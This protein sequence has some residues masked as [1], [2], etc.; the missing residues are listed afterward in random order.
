MQVKVLDTA[1]ALERKIIGWV[2]QSGNGLALNRAAAA[3]TSRHFLHDLAVC[4]FTV[5]GLCLVHVGYRM[6]WNTVIG[7]FLTQI[8]VSFLPGKA[9][10]AED[11]RLVARLPVMRSGSVSPLVVQIFYGFTPRWT[12][13][14]RTSRA[15]CS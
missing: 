7:Y 2:A 12:A 5:W 10:A 8:F 14:N 4:V 9:P 11:S 6:F 13:W 1:V 15:C 3:V